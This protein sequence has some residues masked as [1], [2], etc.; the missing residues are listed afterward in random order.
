M[1]QT[2]DPSGRCWV[3][4]AGVNVHR[5]AG[6]RHTSS[7]TLTHL[8]HLRAPAPGR[9]GREDPQHLEPHQRLAGRPQPF[10]QRLKQLAALRLRAGERQHRRGAEE[11]RARPRAHGPA[12]PLY[13]VEQQEGHGLHGHR[14]RHAA[15]H[16]QGGECLQ[17]DA[18]EVGAAQAWK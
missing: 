11:Q 7:A 14:G 10:L 1:L 18:E 5:W 12:G 9:Q 16:D 2:P 13:R 6:W 17:G 4:T 8:E 15:A 3:H